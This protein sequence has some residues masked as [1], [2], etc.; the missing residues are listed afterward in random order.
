MPTAHELATARDAFENAFGLLRVGVSKWDGSVC[1]LKRGADRF[2]LDTVLFAQELDKRPSA[3]TPEGLALRLADTLGL[4]A[5]ES[6]VIDDVVKAL[7]VLRPRFLHASVMDG[8]GR[9]LVRRELAP[10][11]LLGVSLGRQTVRNFVT[12]RLLD[13]WKMTFDEVIDVAIEE[14]MRRFTIEDIHSLASDPRVLTI[15]HDREPAASVALGL[16]RMV[17]GIDAWPGS[18]IGKPSEDQLLLVPLDE[19][20]DIKDL[21]AIIESTYRIAN[22]HARA[23]SA[24]PCWLYNGVLHTIGLR[25]SDEQASGGR[26]ATVETNHPDVAH[27]LRFL[28]G[29]S[30][31]APPSDEMLG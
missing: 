1:T 13:A 20:S 5:D 14:L 27:L 7:P 23:L 6:L 24:H 28:S 26:R 11:L 4:P 29:E 17:V 8:P 16:D 12:T 19:Q 18:L 9:D 25:M 22:E 10:G 2:S 15:T 30:N 21:G 3:Y 31:E